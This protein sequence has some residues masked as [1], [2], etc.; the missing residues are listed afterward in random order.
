MPTAAHWW[1]TKVAAAAPLADRS[2]LQ[3]ALHNAGVPFL[4]VRK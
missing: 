3:Y 2:L 1:G 4:G